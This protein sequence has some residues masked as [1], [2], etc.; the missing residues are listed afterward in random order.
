MEPTEAELRQIEAEETLDDIL[1][2]A[3]EDAARKR[4]SIP[5]KA[6]RRVSPPGQ[7]KLDSTYK[8]PAN[9]QEVATVKIVHQDASIATLIGDFT[10]FRHKIYPSARKLIRGSF[11]S[12]LPQ[13][14]EYVSD[15]WYI[16]GL[17]ARPHTTQ[18]LD[19]YFN[20]GGPVEIEG[21]F[22]SV[23]DDSTGKRYLRVCAVRGQGI[24][25]AQLG[26]VGENAGGKW[27]FISHDGRSI[28]FLQAGTDVLEGLT[29]AMKLK[30]KEA[31]DAAQG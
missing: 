13:R 4:D 24:A 15:R 23:G 17:A 29:L 8:D 31:F 5:S 22:R 19:L 21:G 12:S 3:I 7:M 1:D 16:E 9:W 27:S 25:R 20:V 10:E 11:L 14:I 30:I 6:A 2:L 18:G 28:L 26:P